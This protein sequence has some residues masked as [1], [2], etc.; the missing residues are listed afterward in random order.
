[1]LNSLKLLIINNMFPFQKY[2]KQSK[3]CLIYYGRQTGEVVRMWAREMEENTGRSNKCVSEN[4][5]WA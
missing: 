2:T 1:M 5:I 3:P 4:E